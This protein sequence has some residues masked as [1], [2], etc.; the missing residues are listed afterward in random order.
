MIHAPITPLIEEAPTTETLG[1]R[2]SRLRRARGLSKTDVADRL[3]ISV[4]AICHWEQ[5]RSRPKAA[6]LQ[7]LS[8][9][10][11]VSATSLLS[12]NSPATGQ[13][14]ADLIAR[15]RAE[16]AHAA[17]TNPAKVRIVIEV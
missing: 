13:S 12:G 5:D 6:R 1:A 17:G 9:L 7:A 15:T 4:A 2:L 16:I 3:T 8:Q 14:L 10:L 11:G